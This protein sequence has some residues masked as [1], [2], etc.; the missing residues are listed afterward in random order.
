MFRKGIFKGSYDYQVVIEL[1]EKFTKKVTLKFYPTFEKPFISKLQCRFQYEAANLYHKNERADALTRE[2]IPVL[3]KWYGGNEFIK[4]T[5]QHP[6]KGPEYV[7]VDAN[8]KIKLSES[9]NGIEVEAV[10]EDLKPLY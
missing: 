7:K 9:D 4:M 2:L 5:S 10:F 6:L 3:M 8:R 1:P